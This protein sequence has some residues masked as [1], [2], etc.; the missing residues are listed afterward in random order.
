MGPKSQMCCA[1]KPNRSR[2]H[3]EAWGP[4]TG[5]NAARNPDPG[6]YPDLPLG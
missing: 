5:K 1:G 4:A 6:P 2:S 3:R